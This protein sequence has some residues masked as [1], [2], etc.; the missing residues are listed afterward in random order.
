M[1][2]LLPQAEDS[3]LTANPGHPA[4]AGAELAEGRRVVDSGLAASDSP[5]MWR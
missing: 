2:A 4:G 3:H 1:R 5:R